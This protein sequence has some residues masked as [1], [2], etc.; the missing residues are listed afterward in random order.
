ML[1]CDFVV[2]DLPPTHSSV[3]SENRMFD[4][5][6]NREI[7]S[8]S[9][10]REFLVSNGFE[11]TFESSLRTLRENIHWHIRKQREKRGTLEFTLTEE[12]GWFSVHSNRSSDWIVQFFEDY[13]FE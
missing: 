13:R 3:W 11:I 6:V 2:F 4:K 5:P 10:M 1:H 7:W 9:K 12:E 8:A